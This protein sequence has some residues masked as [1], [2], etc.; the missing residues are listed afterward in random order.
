MKDFNPTVA[1]DGQG[2]VCFKC[3][4]LHLEILSAVF[5]YIFK[6][7]NFKQYRPKKESV[8][9]FGNFQSNPYICMKLS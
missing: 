6:D 4:L 5:S 1:A 7:K 9:P 3:S 2:T 8:Y